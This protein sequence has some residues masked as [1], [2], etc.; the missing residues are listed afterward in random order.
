MFSPQEDVEKLRRNMKTVATQH[1]SIRQWIDMN[2]QSMRETNFEQDLLNYNSN[3]AQ[4]IPNDKSQN[5]KLDIHYIR[6]ERQVRNET[7][8]GLGE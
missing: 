4:Q 7:I 1:E 2:S 3:A 8:Q 5:S 6:D